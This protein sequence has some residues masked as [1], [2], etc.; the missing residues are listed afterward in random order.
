M[1][2]QQEIFA[3]YNRIADALIESLRNANSPAM[4]QIQQVL[5]RRM[6]LSGDVVPSRIPAP[7]NITEIGGYLNLLEDLK[8]STLRTQM[9]ASALGLYAPVFADFLPES[10]PILYFAEFANDRPGASVDQAAIPVS[11]SVRSDFLAALRAARDA[12]HA[13]GCALPLQNLPRLLPSYIGTQPTARDLLRTIGRTIEIM[14][15]SALR[16]PDIDP[17]AVARPADDSETEQVVARVLNT[18]TPNAV[19][20]SEREWTAWVFDQVSGEHVESVASR[21]YAPIEPILAE[22]GWYRFLPIDTSGLGPPFAW[23]RFVNITGL[24]PGLTVYGD[25]LALLY[26]REE[27]VMSSVR[28]CVDW[29]WNGT[30]FAE[31][32]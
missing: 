28:D 18:I 29:V 1:A 21:R 14:P 5:A 4:S 16:D 30:D 2:N 20:V 19:D 3:L 23:A 15:S 25:E 26:R 9:I 22:A 13:R 32:E 8:H 31:V 12:V 17:L 24:V 7:L 10:G 11:I 6:A 27:V